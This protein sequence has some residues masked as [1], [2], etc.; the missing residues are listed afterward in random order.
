MTWALALAVLALSACAPLQQ[1]ALTPVTPLEPGF[2]DNWFTSFDG[3]RLGLNIYPARPPAAGAGP[4]D[5]GAGLNIST[6]ASA[7]AAASDIY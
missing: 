7:C 3:A 2:S 4:C 5:N 1:A 6:V